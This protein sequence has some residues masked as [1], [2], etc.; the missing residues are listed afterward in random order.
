LGEL[1]WL[2][3]QYVAGEL[4]MDEAER[5]EQRLGLDQSAREAVAKAVELTRVT[6]LA[7]GVEKAGE[8]HGSD[9]AAP[10]VV[11]GWQKR[12]A[13]IA[14]GVAASI[15]LTWFI[16]DALLGTRG[17]QF[18]KTSSVTDAGGSG[19]AVEAERDLALAWARHA[20]EAPSEG[21]V[22]LSPSEPLVE[23]DD[24]G[25]PDFDALIG[26]PSWMLSAVA[27]LEGSPDEGRPIIE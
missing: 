23:A 6:A 20:E 9:L 4:S 10:C 5:F 11:S 14:G 15:A 16:A 7:A 18:V 19:Q 17:G 3:F 26:P 25:G 12:V 1:D 22:G 27:S 8:T 24:N 21:A 13:W 2:A